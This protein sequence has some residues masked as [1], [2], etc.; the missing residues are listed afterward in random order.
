[1]HRMLL[2]SG[3]KFIQSHPQKS[4]GEPDLQEITNQVWEEINEHCQLNNVILDVQ[5]DDG[6]IGDR[7]ILAYASRTLFLDG[8]V[9]RSGALNSQGHLGSIRIRVNRDVPNGWY[10]DDGTCQPGYRYDLRT[11][12]RH[13]IA[14]G[15][16]VSSSI[17][18]GSVGYYYGSECYPT[19]FDTLIEDENNQK[20]VSACSHSHTFGEKAYVDGIRLYSPST[21]NKGSS[22]SHTHEDGL[23]WYAIYPME[24]H[25]YDDNTI[26][27]LN[28]IG[29]NCVLPESDPSDYS[30][31]STTSA[32]VDP[33]TSAPV[34]PS[35]MPST[36]SSGGQEVPFFAL[37][38]CLLLLLKWA[39]T[40]HSA[41]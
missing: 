3:W 37:Y 16:G 31:E 34:D 20:V 26:A 32:P 29:A 10:V 30:P 9:W 18:P 22:L 5:Y 41:R 38:I 2:M 27:L 35:P 33:T 36:L 11:V 25:P 4:L 21:Y 15:I 24:C 13:E 8:D 12:L 7:P 1:M 40:I 39:S 19:M 17:A 6:V 14:H 23:M 28:A